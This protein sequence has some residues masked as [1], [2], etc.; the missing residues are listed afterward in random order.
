MNPTGL[1]SV[2]LT[3][4]SITVTTSTQEFQFETKH[5]MKKTRFINLP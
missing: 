5:L 4:N 1:L 3:E 2:P